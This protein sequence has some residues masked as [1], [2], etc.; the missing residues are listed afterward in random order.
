MAVDKPFPANMK[1]QEFDACPHLCLL[2]E[3]RVFEDADRLWL[4]GSPVKIPNASV[5]VERTLELLN[6]GIVLATSEQYVASTRLVAPYAKLFKH[7]FDLMVFKDVFGVAYDGYT[8]RST[9][10]SLILR[11]Q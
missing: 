5:V 9:L 8:F 2:D 11:Y 6:G 4:P 7:I 1:G 10:K 3:A